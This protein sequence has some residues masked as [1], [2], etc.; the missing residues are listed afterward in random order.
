MGTGTGTGTGTGKLAIHV[1][2]NTSRLPLTPREKRV[3]YREE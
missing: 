2:V 3:S 1:A